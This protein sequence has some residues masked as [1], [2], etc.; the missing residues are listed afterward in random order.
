MTEKD[1]SKTGID[2]SA[3]SF[4]QALAE[5]EKIVESL[6]QGEVPLDK[7][8]E[9]YER[10]EALRNHCRKLLQAAEDKVEKIRLSPDGKAAGTE[11]LDG[12]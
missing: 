7:S 8:I 2:V 1:A 9:Q 11:P 10:G 12:K 3:L 4:E 5:L 6:E